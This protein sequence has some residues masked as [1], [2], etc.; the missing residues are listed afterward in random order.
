M[1]PS[2]NLLNNCD[3]SRVS[4]YLYW[5]LWPFLY[6]GHR[7]ISRQLGLNDFFRGSYGYCFHMI[8]IKL[9]FFF[10][11]FLFRSLAFVSKR[12]HIVAIYSNNAVENLLFSEMSLVLC[13]QWGFTYF[14]LKFVQ[15]ERKCWNILYCACVLEI[16][17]IS[18][19]Y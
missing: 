10:S 4:L 16:P 14:K 18:V 9:F 12:F 19:L 5:L 1:T 11:V 2:Q 8:K 15:R 7:V 13:Y 6:Q 3:P 17:H